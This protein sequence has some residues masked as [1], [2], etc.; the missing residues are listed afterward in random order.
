MAKAVH[1]ETIHIIQ[2][3]QL[4]ASLSLALQIYIFSL[5]LLHNK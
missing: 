1:T 3:W 5:F 2:S 4:F